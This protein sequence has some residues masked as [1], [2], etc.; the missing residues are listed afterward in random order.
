MIARSR[1]PILSPMKPRCLACLFLLLPLC[2][3]RADKPHELR[4]IGEW[5]DG[6]GEVLV[7]TANKLRVGS[8]TSSYKEIA[9]SKDERS[10]RFQVTSGGGG[11]DGRFLS[12]EVGREEMSMREYRTLADC[13]DDKG[14][15]A[16]V[17]WSRDR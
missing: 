10:F 6:R 13:L 1:P 16:V 5:S 17:A 9:R 15:A 11:L 14:V 3:A 4:Y 2:L 7:V 8:R 12:I